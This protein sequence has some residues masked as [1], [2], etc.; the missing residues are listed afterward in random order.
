MLLDT[1]AQGRII[2]RNRGYWDGVSAKARN[3]WP[4]WT[5]SCLYRGKHPFDALYGEG[6][7]TG[8]YGETPP[9]YALTGRKAN[10]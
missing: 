2:R 10:A 7:W 4:V 9:P 3:R 5:K 8:W 1:T 6:F